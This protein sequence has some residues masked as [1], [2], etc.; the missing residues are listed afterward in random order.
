MKSTTDYVPQSFLEDL[1]PEA[2]DELLEQLEMM[3]AA[4]PEIHPYGSRI[5]E[6]PAGWGV[7]SEAETRH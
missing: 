5:P 7:V 1:T 3:F 2:F 4:C 6:L